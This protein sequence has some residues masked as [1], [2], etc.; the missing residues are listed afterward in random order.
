MKKAFSMLAM[1]VIMMTMVTTLRS[2]NDDYEWETRYH[3]NNKVW[4]VQQVG[5]DTKDSGD[6]STSVYGST[7]QNS[8]SHGMYASA[9]FN[10][11][12]VNPK[13]TGTWY[14]RAHL[15]VEWATDEEPFEEDGDIVGK[16]EG[17]SKSGKQGDVDWFANH[18]PLDTIEIIDSYAEAKV[19]L[20]KGAKY[21]SVAYS[22]FTPI[23][24]NINW[25][26]QKP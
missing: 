20:V 6:L 23:N 7:Q 4:R 13:V 21:R 14:L 8:Y 24:I 5:D 10:A 2:N 9:S 11:D 18:D 19:T 15:N 16:T 1:I 22:H 12:Y 3:W 17:T 26:E 25:V